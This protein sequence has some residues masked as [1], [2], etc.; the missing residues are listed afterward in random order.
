MCNIYKAKKKK[1][2]SMG[3][4]ESKDRIETLKAK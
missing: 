3:K 2:R 4:V 1:N